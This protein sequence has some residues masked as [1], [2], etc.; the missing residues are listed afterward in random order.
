MFVVPDYAY[1][2]VNLSTTV[3]ASEKDAKV[4]QDPAIY[5]CMSTEVTLQVFKFLENIFSTWAWFPE[6]TV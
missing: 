1:E 3:E 4:V 6:Y 5:I 2:S